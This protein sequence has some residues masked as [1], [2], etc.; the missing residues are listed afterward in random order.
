MFNLDAVLC[1]AVSMPSNMLLLQCSTLHFR[2]HNRDSASQMNEAS[3]TPAAAD[4][5]GRATSKE[6]TIEVPKP[7]TVGAS[8]SNRARK[9]VQ[10][11]DI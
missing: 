7:A 3:E 9:D 6:E 5:G 1:S 11:N 10:I 2:Q 8:A 4:S